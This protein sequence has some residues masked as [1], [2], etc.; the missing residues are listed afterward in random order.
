MKR[1]LLYSLLACI[2]ITNSCKKS[3]SPA[4]G[5][6]PIPGLPA[7]GVSI[8]TSVFGRVVDEKDLPLSDVSISGGGSSTTTDINGIYILKD[9][10]LDQARAYVTAAKT[11]FFKGS[12]IFRPVKDGMS[13]PPLIKMLA[14]KS[15]GTISA[16][17]GGSVES[18]GG[19][20]VELPAGAIASYTGQVNVVA[21]Y[22]NPTSPDFFARMPG[23]LAADNA[24]GKRGAL[25]SYGMSNIDLIDDKGNKLAIKSGAQ[26]TITLPIPASLKANATSTIAM[27][28]FD[29]EK[30]LWKEEGSGALQNGKYVGKVSHFSTWNFDHWNPTMVLPIFLR[31]I[32]P[33]IS[34]MPPEDLDNVLNHPPDFTVQLKDKPTGNTLYTTTLPPLNRTTTGDRGGTV[35]VS[36]PVP[37][38]TSEMTVT[39]QPVQPGGPDYPTNT[40]YNPTQD[41][42]PP[43]TPTFATEQESVTVDYRPTNPPTTIT[44][45]YPPSG[46]AGG[47]G[48]TIVNVNGKAVNCSNKAVTAGY[49]FLSMRSGNTIVKSTTAP[50]YGTEGRFTAQYLFMNP[51]PNKID[52][53][54]LTVY[55]VQT[56]K[57]SADL[58]YNINPSV[59][60]MIPDPVSVCDQNGGTPGTGGKVLNGSYSIYDAASLKAFIDSA[61]TEVTGQLTVNNVDNLGGITTLKKVSSL[62]INRTP[63]K[64]LGGL[65]ELEQITGNLTIVVNQ[66]LV[67]AA[68][69]KLANKTLAGSIYITSNKSLVAVTLPSLE[70]VAT[71]GAFIQISDNPLLTTLSIP[72]LKSVDKCDHI[73]IDNTLLKNLDVFANATGTTGDWGMDLTDNPELLSVTGL[74]KITIGGRLTVTQ[75]P[76]LT[77]L[78]GI[79][80]KPNMQDWVNVTYN[81][82]LTDMTAVNSKLVSATSYGAS[83]NDALT[84]IS[85][86]LLQT[87]S[88]LGIDTDPQ[89]TKLNVPVLTSA[90][91]ITVNEV[92]KLSTFNISTLQNMTG[93][94]Y[95]NGG[96]NN[97]P[98]TN[99]DL[100]ALK[101]CNGFEIHNFPAIT[102]IDGFNNLETVGSLTIENGVFTGANIRLKTING[103]NKLKTITYS[104]DLFNATG[105]DHK[106]PLTTIKGFSQLTDM[107]AGLSITGLNLTDISGFKNLTSVREMSISATGLTGLDGFSK[108][109]N[110][111]IPG[112]DLQYGVIDINNNP[113]LIT[114]SGLSSLTTTNGIYFYSNPS[115]KDVNGLEKVKSMTMS[116][117]LTDNAALTNLDGL[118]NVTGNTHSLGIN[119][120]PKLKNLC[121]LT[122]IVKDGGTLDS[123]QVSGNGYNPTYN[124]LK[125]GSCSK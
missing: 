98:L 86:P 18:P 117:R 60:Y 37:Q 43:A 50:V 4:P 96:Y 107:G 106:A 30:G 40:H 44:I 92:P 16:A 75:N 13:R 78:N 6:G 7:E 20:K 45:T 46:M 52:N 47:N 55:D 109:T 19:I 88:G 34:S 77:S 49:A 39:I 38:V 9:V 48:E 21:A 80:I 53:V 65:A 62:E 121:G 42:T 25:I 64:D 23:D 11:G 51:M 69:P 105:S 32:L 72:N 103:F 36:I 108:L 2:L 110:A 111:K 26:A 67:N 56:G 123:Y 27:W 93:R 100:P 58:K 14:Q 81:A 90:A 66:N 83:H 59:A 112:T 70:T 3:D 113:N 61:Y 5:P 73:N 74:S 119:D 71:N 82:Q 118:A 115:L 57:K 102:N 10:R 29:E 99:L 120:N 54:V 79:N 101:K 28:H 41:E 17:A 114:T 122:K 31:W 87:V 22:L 89:L 33:N 116:I 91:D 94:L 12:R 85:L 35:T 95:L 97:C 104:L 84:D 8:T 124:D 1:Y 63:L 15:I 68:F 76:R 125:A 24:S